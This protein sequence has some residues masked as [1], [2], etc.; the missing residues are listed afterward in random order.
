MSEYYAELPIQVKLNGG[1]HELGHFAS[2]VAN[3]PR[4]VTLN[5]VELKRDEKSGDLELQAVAKTYRYLDPEEVAEQQR[6][7]AQERKR[8]RR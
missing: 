3:L 7:K 6:L 5:N 4:I 1:Y 8:T 2:D